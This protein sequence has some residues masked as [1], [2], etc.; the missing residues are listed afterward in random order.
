M[1]G[2]RY[3]SAMPTPFGMAPAKGTRPQDAPQRRARLEGHAQRGVCRCRHRPGLGRLP[4]P[5]P[6]D[7]RSRTSS[8]GG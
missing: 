3:Q 7:A 4:H 5:S 1:I 6:Y 2:Q 8:G